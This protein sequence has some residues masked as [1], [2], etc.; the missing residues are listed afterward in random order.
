[1]PAAVFS[2]ADAVQAVLMESG[3]C[4][5]PDQAKAAADAALSFATEALKTT[6]AVDRALWDAPG[7][8]DYQRQR[9][10]TELLRTLWERGLVPVCM[11]QEHTEFYDYERHRNV[12]EDDP[13]W[14]WATITMWVAARPASAPPTAAAVRPSATN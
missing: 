12:P 5:H 4:L 9:L 3:V 1:M 14:G 6:G 11:P 2:A 7:M 13:D 8:V 10:A